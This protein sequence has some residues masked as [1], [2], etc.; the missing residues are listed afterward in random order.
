MVAYGVMNFAWKMARGHCKLGLESWYGSRSIRD[1]SPGGTKRGLEISVDMRLSDTRVH[2]HLPTRKWLRKVR[3]RGQFT[4]TSEGRNR[5]VVQQRTS[6][7]EAIP[8]ST[9][10]KKSCLLDNT[11]ASR[12]VGLVVRQYA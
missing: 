2:A 4:S 5:L 7:S 11:P 6:N 3:T 8:R 9:F 1:C 10:S 12:G